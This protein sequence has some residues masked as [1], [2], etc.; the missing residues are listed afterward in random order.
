MRVPTRI[1]NETQVS[2]FGS[3]VPINLF[4]LCLCLPSHTRL[5]TSSPLPSI[6]YSYNFSP[7]LSPPL[8]TYLSPLPPSG[9]V[10]PQRPFP[11]S[12][13]HLSPTPPLVSSEQVFPGLSATTCTFLGSSALYVRLFCMHAFFMLV[14]A[15]VCVCGWMGG[16]VYS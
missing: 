2:I 7:Y 5:V 16:W 10:S 8:L 12:H 13:P 4:P 3:A 9:S 1:Q 6:S 14:C 15:N 11:V